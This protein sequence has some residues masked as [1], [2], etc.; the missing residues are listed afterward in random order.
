M[1][2]TEEGAVPQIHFFYYYYFQTGQL[3]QSRGAHV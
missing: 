3:L 2:L 1:V